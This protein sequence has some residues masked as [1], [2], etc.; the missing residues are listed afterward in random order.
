M[1]SRARVL[2]L[3]A[4]LVTAC[5]TDAGSAALASPLVGEDAVTIV[6]RAGD[7]TL[8]RGAASTPL[9]QTDERPSYAMQ[10]RGPNGVVDSP[11]PAL[12]GALVP[13]GA[14]WVL[15]DGTLRSADG[16]LVDRDALPELAV[17]ADGTQLAYARHARAGGGVV[18]IELATG[19]RHLASEGLALADRPLFLP[20][21]RLVVVG[22]RASGVAGV[23]IVDPRGASQ[24]LALTNATLRVGRPF[25]DA[26]VPPPA[27]HESMRVEAGALV[28]DDGRAEQRV[29][30]PEAS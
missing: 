29:T 23:W 1:R 27:Y 18:V 4:V 8:V 15:V 11:G 13:G 21:G 20:D 16:T 3:V 2:S 22:A 26:F 6:A 28:Y 19:A 9:A 17:S 7:R 24:P 14:V 25:G 12:A 30:L 5:A 10:V